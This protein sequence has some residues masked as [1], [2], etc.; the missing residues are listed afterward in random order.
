MQVD[1]HQHIWT[2][3][4]LDALAARDCLPFVRREAGLTVLHSADELPYVI[5]VPSESP[6]RCAALAAADGI[7]RAL[8]AIS[9]PIG[10]ES[11]PR[12]SARGLIAAHL[13]GVQALGDQFG[14]W[15]PIPLCEPD[16]ADVDDV[17]A[18]GCVGVSLPAG[19]LATPEALAVAAPL[20]G[21]PLWWRALTQYV[22]QMEAA[23]LVFATRGRREHPELV[24]VFAM[25][26]G[27]APLLAER[28]LTRGGPALDL[29]DPRVF[30]D[31]SSYGP[32]AVATMAG[33]VGPDQLLYGSDRPVLEPIPTEWDARLK[34]NAAQLALHSAAPPGVASRK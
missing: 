20:L 14:A 27:C 12:A 15:G 21:E 13:A 31:S 33:L 28:L 19:A 1:I 11:L 23:W 29:R 22:A 7:D 2:E 18:S 32:T 17:L 10:I 6:S 25:L 3:P 16:P 26:A 24:V 30:Y 4:L 34:A 5:D 8:I 9:S